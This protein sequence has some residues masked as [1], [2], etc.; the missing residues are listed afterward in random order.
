MTTNAP[1]EER[2]KMNRDRMIRRIA[3]NTHEEDDWTSSLQLSVV[4]S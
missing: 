1:Q 4:L 3:S 2:H